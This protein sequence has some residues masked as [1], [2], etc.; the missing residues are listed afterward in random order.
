MTGSTPVAGCHTTHLG[1]AALGKLL[2]LIALAAIS[3]H[4]LLYVIILYAL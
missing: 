3:R 4:M 2:T 1:V